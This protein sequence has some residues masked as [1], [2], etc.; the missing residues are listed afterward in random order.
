M[1]R[2][3]RQL[4]RYDPRAATRSTG[5][6]SELL[7]PPIDPDVALLGIGNSA[8]E[9]TLRCQALAAMD[10]FTLIAAG[11]NN[12]RLAPR[13][14]TVRRADGAVL[15]LQLSERL[16][17]DGDNPRDLMRDYPL[18]EQR[19]ARLL[20]GVPVFETYPRAGA[21]GHGLPA[22]SA[23]DIDLHIESVLALLR[24][25]LRRLRDEPPAAI[26]QS[27][28]QSIVAQTQH[29]RAPREKRI[30][31][32]GGGCGAMGNAGHHLI[33]YLI[34]TVLAEQ[35]IDDYQLWGVVLG[36]RTFSGLTPF[37]RHNFR[38][39]MEALEYMSRHGQRR[40]YI[41][42]LRIDMRQPPYDYV[43]LFDDPSLPGEGP[44]VTEAE[45]EVFLDRAALSLSL[46]I[47]GSVWQTVA[48]HIANEDGVARE[49]G[50]LRYLSTM[51]G[52]V[53]GADRAQLAS[54]LT[55]GL[56]MRVLDRLIQRFDGSD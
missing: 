12:D 34:R 43:F 49:D 51:H 9:V 15:P 31:V 38:A 35:G 20:R 29:D 3:S 32:I 40:A 24:R 11:L 55:A 21:G 25:L 30:L 19:Y 27:R 48:S 42:D 28:I 56:E 33:P 1:D 26:G 45:M 17:I 53:V 39:L 13:P 16:V 10:D 52:V 47:R 7:R 18:L 23:L 4:R 8:E 14:I 37:V 2:T 36:P 54:L 22:I 6:S 41:N 44:K 50:R 5:E 46:L